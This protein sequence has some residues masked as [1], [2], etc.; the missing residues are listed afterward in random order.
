MLFQH[1]YIAYI[2]QIK[3]IGS[4]EEGRG[5]GS[6]GGRR[7]RSKLGE[8]GKQV[9]RM[10]GSQRGPGLGGEP[11]PRGLSGQHSHSWHGFLSQFAALR[12][13][14]SRLRRD[15]ARVAVTIP[16]LLSL[17][18]C[19]VNSSLG[20]S[21]FFNGERKWQCAEK[22]LP[23]HKNSAIRFPPHT[24]YKKQLRMVGT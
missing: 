8:H 19:C 1:L 7:R 9:R 24:R 12:D 15:R 23:T 3:L 22:C 16:R 21:T 13:L 20:E 6:R 17:Q 10:G 18:K 4:W 14:S 5:E 11:C 2:Y